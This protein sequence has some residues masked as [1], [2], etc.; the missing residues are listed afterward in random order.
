MVL[1]HSTRR[2]ISIG[3]MLAVPLLVFAQA[4]VQTPAE[5]KPVLEAGTR[6]IRLDPIGIRIRIPDDVAVREFTPYSNSVSIASEVSGDHDMNLEIGFGPSSC[7][8]WYNSKVQLK[9]GKPGKLKTGTPMYDA[10]WYPTYFDRKGWIYVCLDRPGGSVYI[11]STPLRNLPVEPFL[12]VTANIADAFLPDSVKAASAAAPAA[13]TSA[14]SVDNLYPHFIEPS[15]LRC[16]TEGSASACQAVQTFEAVHK[17]CSDGRASACF[18]IAN[19]A[20]IFGEEQTAKTYYQRS[21]DLGETT[22]CKKSK[23]NG[24]KPGK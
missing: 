19:Q 11:E 5:I 23:G 2:S 4:P 24:W 3:C 18:G 9:S 12:H 13:P 1:S 16:R 10:R 20:A 21:C 17:M 14:V 8:D 15:A 22:A 7:T 6:T